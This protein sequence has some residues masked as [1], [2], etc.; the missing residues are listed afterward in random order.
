MTTLTTTAGTS[1]DAA[2]VAAMT[3]QMVANHDA[4]R[5]LAWIMFDCDLLDYDTASQNPPAFTAMCHALIGKWDYGRGQEAEAVNEALAQ[6]YDG[7]PDYTQS[8]W[9]A[10]IDYSPEERDAAVPVLED[11]VKVPGVTTAAGVEI[12]GTL[13]RAISVAR[14]YVENAVH[15]AEGLALDLEDSASSREEH[16]PNADDTH[17]ARESANDVSMMVHRLSSIHWPGEIGPAADAP[18]V[19]VSEAP[20]VTRGP[21]KG[22]PVKMRP[23]EMRR[24][25]LEKVNDWLAAAC[26]QLDV[27]L[28]LAAAVDGELSP[29]AIQLLSEILESVNRCGIDD[30]E[31]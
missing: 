28:F 5:Q 1:A 9:G 17:E 21:R 25:Y 22:Q 15:E 11:I 2:Q 27:D 23:G 7:F 8:I 18:P 16:F 4:A 20:A 12:S 10:L 24:L 29:A 14:C 30:I 26:E 31:L 6:A 19:A 13:A 3:Q